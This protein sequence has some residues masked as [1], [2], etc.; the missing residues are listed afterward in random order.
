MAPEII[1]EIFAD[2]IGMNASDVH[3]E[4][5]GE[6]V[7]IRF[8]IDG[9]LMEAGRIPKEFYENILNR[10]KVQAHMPIDEHFAAQDGA[11]RYV[12]EDNH[13]DMRVSIVPTLDG[14]KVVIRVL[15]QYV[16]GLNLKDLGLS[17]K[18]EQMFIAASNKPFGM[19]IVSGPTGSGKSTSLYA[20]LKFLNSSEINITSIEDPVEYRLTGVNQIQVNPQTNLTFAKGLK[21]IVRQDPDVILVGEIRDTETA[22]I[23]V[24]AALSGHLLFSTFHANDAPT[25]I[26]RLLDM[27]I[28]PFLLSS[29][30]E[31]V[32]AQRLVRRICEN[33]RL[34]YTIELD[35]LQKDFPLVNIEKYFGKEDDITLYKGKGCPNCHG[36]GFK[37]RIAIFEF[38]EISPKIEDLMLKHPSTQEI[39]ELAR[40][41][42]AVCLFEDGLDKVKSGVTTLDEL[43]RMAE[44][45]AE[46]KRAL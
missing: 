23:A 25:T 35:Q 9:V 36:T 33:C 28:E 1:D 22:E 6:E 18:H 2:A 10:I 8:R 12:K 21:S 42:G 31:L 20:L 24:N 43:L 13:V 16:K 26:P 17:E 30:L 39:W 14:E 5:Q 27:G 32:I 7:I 11:I 40:S 46:G 45:P 38:V 19:I 4:P 29:T 15:S 37:G 44:P 41:E 3:F 34:S